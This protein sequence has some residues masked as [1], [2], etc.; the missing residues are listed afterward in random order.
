MGMFDH[1]QC[2]YP[3]PGA[4]KPTGDFNWENKWIPF[5]GLFQSKDLEC[6]LHKYTITKEGNL[7]IERYWDV[8]DVDPKP[9]PEQCYFTGWLNF[10]HY[11]GH[12]PKDDHKEFNYRAEFFRG[13]LMAIEGGVTKRGAKATPAHGK[14]GE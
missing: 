1:I 9:S 12:P 11:E 3:L 10:Y 8:G 5:S 7:V 14:E 13:K 2:D 4:E 6:E